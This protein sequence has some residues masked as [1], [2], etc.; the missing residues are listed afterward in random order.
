MLLRYRSLAVVA[1]LVA[2]ASAAEPALAAG[3]NVRIDPATQT[4]AQGS[5]FTVHIIQNYSS[6]SIGVQA[7][8]AFDQSK[9]Q[10]QT[11]AKGAPFASAP[12]FVPTDLAGAIAKANGNGKLEQIAAAFLPPALTSAGDQDF[13]DVTFQATGCGQVSLTLPAGPLDTQLLDNAGHAVTITTTGASV[14]INNCSGDQGGGSQGGGSQPTQTTNPGPGTSQAGVGATS[15]SESS[16]GEAAPASSPGEAAAASSQTNGD[17]GQ[18]SAT[19]TADTAGAANSTSGSG[20]ASGT[21]D[22]P[23]LWLPIILAIPAVAVI[24]L[25]LRK[26]RLQE[27]G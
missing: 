7:T 9:L 26:W 5:T 12:V 20:P 15:S 1:V 22:T 3:P 13:L 27:L 24:W 11:V 8:L 10:I 16:P 25:G 4:V 19:G 18:N 14:T 21:R 6:T 23:P 17:G 2:L